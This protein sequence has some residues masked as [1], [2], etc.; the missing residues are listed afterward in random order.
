M[1]WKPTIVL[2]N[3][4]FIG[5]FSILLSI[6]HEHKWLKF[7]IPKNIILNILQ[8]IFVNPDLTKEVIAELKIMSP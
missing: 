5:T 3:V 4:L 8:N 2:I 6:T 7:A 1:Q